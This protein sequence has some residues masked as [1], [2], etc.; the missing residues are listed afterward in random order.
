MF[1]DYRAGPMA[2]NDADIAAVKG[3]L[4]RAEIGSTTWLLIRHIATPI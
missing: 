2:L 3:M 1:S 4:G